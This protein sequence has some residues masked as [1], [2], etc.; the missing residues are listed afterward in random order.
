MLHAAFLQLC[1]WEQNLKKESSPHLMWS[2]CFRHPGLSL[3]EPQFCLIFNLRRSRVCT[4]SPA[5]GQVP[6]TRDEPAVPTVGAWGL[7]KATPPSSSPNPLPNTRYQFAS[8]GIKMT[9]LTN[10]RQTHQVT[11]ARPPIKHLDCHWRTLD[12][13]SLE[14][15]GD[16][17][18]KT[19]LCGTESQTTREVAPPSVRAVRSR[20]QGLRYGKGLGESRHGGE[21]ARR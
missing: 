21:T 12:S 14:G 8:P 16:R 17:R 5:L 13:L 15:P 7:G 9:P 11:C 18:F 3:H 20:V 2:L 4:A 19:G 1:S 6:G 10:V